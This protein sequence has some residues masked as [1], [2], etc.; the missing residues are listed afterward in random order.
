MS[1]TFKAYAARTKGTKLEPFEFNPGPLRDEQVEIQIEYCGICH[2]D[3]SMLD[4]EWGMTEYPFVPGHEVAGRVVAA[5][6]KVKGVKVGQRVGLGWY[7]ESCMSCPQCLSGNH[8]LCPTAEGTMIKRHGV[9]PMIEV[10]PMSKVNDAMEHL[11]AGKAR[12][13]IVLQNDIR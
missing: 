12:Y 7:A 11:R 2:S 13:R 3:L 10:F 4:N 5:G 6:D 8:N 1:T 9:A